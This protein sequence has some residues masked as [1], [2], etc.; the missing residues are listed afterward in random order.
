MASLKERYLSVRQVA[1][2]AGMTKARV[3]QLIRDGAI[4]VDDV[5]GFLLVKRTDAVKVQRERK[6]Y[7]RNPAV[8]Q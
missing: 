2:L 1:E 4:P 7:Q 6:R 5:D 3:H 8:G